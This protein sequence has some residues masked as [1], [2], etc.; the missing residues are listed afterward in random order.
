M[1][2]VCIAVTALSAVFDSIGKA[3][4]AGLLGKVWNDKL[5]TVKQESKEVLGRC[6]KRMWGQ[7]TKAEAEKKAAASEAATRA[8]TGS[9][10]RRAL[11][12]YIKGMWGQPTKAEA[13]KEAAASEAATWASTGSTPRRAC[14]QDGSVRV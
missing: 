13:E 8:S 10:P 11:G 14:T 3:Q 4:N 6:I 7:P 5:E 1:N 2:M 12:R 9:T